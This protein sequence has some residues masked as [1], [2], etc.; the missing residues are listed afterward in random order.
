MTGPE[1]REQLIEVGRS[2]FAA[3]GYEAATVEEIAEAAE[4]SKP[5]VYEHFG[6]KDGLYDVV[7]ERAITDLSDRIAVGMVHGPSRR[8]AEAAAAAFLAF[9]EDEE[10]SFRVL[11]HDGPGRDGSLGIVIETAAART[12]ELLAGQF[13]DLG[14]DPEVAP[15]Y[16]RMLVGAT[17]LVGQWWLDVRRPDRDEV[18]RHIVNLMW[19][20]LRH[21]DPE[22]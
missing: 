5:I 9:I 18:A 4:V 12:E 14:F 17:A 2:V 11:L 6:G 21:L 1:R 16:A 10:D 15:M 22:P 8:S 7:V 20:G 3:R 13:A 19:N